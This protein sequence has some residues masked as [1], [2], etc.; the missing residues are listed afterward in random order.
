MGISDLVKSKL[1]RRTFIQG[2]AAAGAAVTVAGCSTDD[3]ELNFGTV[4]PAN[5]VQ[6]EDEFL[7]QGYF[8][9]GTSA[10]NCGG[11]CL[12]KA[13]VVDGKIVRFLTDDAVATAENDVIDTEN[14]NCTQAKACSKCRSYKFRLYHPGRLKYPLKQTVKRG[15]L[16]GFVRVSWEE[17][18]SDISTK[19]KAITD[20]YGYEAFHSIYAC[21]NIASKWQGGGY[22]GLLAGLTGRDAPFARLMGGQ[23]TYKIDYSF[24]QSSFFSSGNQS[25]TGY[26]G[27]QS[28]SANAIASVGKNIVLWG[29]NILSTVNPV[30]YSWIK[31]VE[32]FK[33]R[34]DT[35]MVYFIG[36]EF[37]D[38]G[39]TL[40]DEWLQIR[41]YTD[42]AIFMAMMYHMIINTFKDDGSLQAEPMLD[43]NYLDTMVYG[44]FDNP[45][46]WIHNTTR[47]IVTTDPSDAANYTYVESTEGKSLATYIM[48]SDTRLQNAVYNATGNSYVATQ[49]G[50]ATRGNAS[51][52]VAPADTKFEYKTQFAVAKTPAWA[53]AISGMPAEKIIELAELY[54]NTDNHPIWSEWSGGQMKQAEGVITKFAM[55][56]LMLVTKCWGQSA[57]GYS[58]RG[59]DVTSTKAGDPVEP[60]ISYASLPAHK[61]DVVPSVTQ[62]HNAIKM[63]FGED[64]K[65]GG[66]TG[67][68]IP[69]WN[70][71]DIGDGKVYHDDGGAKALV[72]WQ[73]NADGTIQTDSNG[74]YM[75]EDDGTGKP[76]YSGFRFILNSAGN[77]PVNQHMNCNDSVEMY[78]ALPIAFG[79]ADD[80]ETFCLV[81]FDNFL[82]PSARWSDYVLPAATTWEQEDYIG[83]FGAN[84]IYIP[85][86]IT[87]PGE[88]KSSWDFCNEWLKVYETVDTNKQGIATMFTGGVADQ[89]IGDLTKKDFDD[90][91]VDPTSP[92]YGKTWEQF[93]DNPYLPN[94]PASDE[95]FVAS[96]TDLRKSLNAYLAS[97]NISTTPF[98]ATNSSGNPL[99]TV[100]T[101]GQIT[102]I[103]DGAVFTADALTI[104][105]G[106]MGGTDFVNPEDC[107]QPSGRFHVFSGAFKWRYEN[108]YNKFHGFLPANERGQNN[109]DS[110][111]DPIVW[112][113]PMY[114]SY[115]D[116]FVEAYGLNSAADLA[117]RYLLT[118]THDRHRAH[119]S[120][121]ENP[122]LRELTHRTVGGGLYSGNDYKDY[123]MI[124]GQNVA[125]DGTASLDTLNRLIGADGTNAKDAS[126]SEIWINPDNKEGIV[127]GD[128][129][130][131]WNEIGT[132]RCVARTSYRCVP[133]FLG[134]HQGC[135][136]DPR[137]IDGNIVD[138]GGNC[139]TL[140]ATKPSRADHGNAQQ[141]AMVQIKKVQA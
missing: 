30:A 29:S 92:F 51:E 7:D 97:A 100:N 87:P 89:S 45:E 22:T 62:W 4:T 68:Y 69:D 21:G 64:L 5:T 34:S 38:M 96:E 39:V 32:D 93:L 49:F 111:G 9:Y 3:G 58:R 84:S 106:F 11:R 115:Q 136:Y 72:K 55:D 16:S 28:T 80:A 139:N 42:N 107:P 85:S 91:K 74:Y 126:Y 75:W 123:A 65:A 116:Y 37:S 95:G 129:V 14:R 105:Y 46:Y 114:Y 94:K 73:R 40:A 26:P 88:S 2:M 8:R 52:Y 82:A 125:V 59:F 15:D 53:A 12:I 140:M 1:S 122:Y 35:G 137:E 130:E 61:Q 133:G 18:L 113:I 56:A 6:S 79:A 112:E 23:T 20:K 134:L 41:P 99:T 138:V 54:A 76:L 31:G 77:I 66:Y 98:I 19:F 104:G 60:S 124:D 13:Q 102:G 108:R 141:S 17:A 135:W 90:K 81:T 103:K 27:A 48:G 86:V 132:V 70:S 120:Q 33:K 57:N 128:L 43:V 47:E 127:D 83:L 117:G 63:A 25:Y 131:V 44:F 101:L 121:S 78:E 50:T 67:K 119:S 118:T 110:E 10:H 71:A 24:H 109:I 36:P